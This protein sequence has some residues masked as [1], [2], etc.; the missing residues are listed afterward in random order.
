[1]LAKK[2]SEHSVTLQVVRDHLI[3][4][5]ILSLKMAS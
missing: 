2:D 4:W 3:S 1:M 5:Y